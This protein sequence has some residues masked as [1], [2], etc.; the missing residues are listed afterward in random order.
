M[1]KFQEEIIK[2]LKKETKLKEISLEIPSN[3]ELGDYAFPCFVLSKQMKKN[4]VDIAK[5]LVGKISTNDIIKEVKSVGPYLNFFVNRS[6]Q[7]QDL[8]KNILKKGDDFGKQKFTGKKILVEFPGPNTNKPLHLGHVR[9]IVLGTT[10]SKILEMNGHKAVHVNVN[11]DRGIAICKS[12]LAYQKW[13]KNDTP[14]KSKM[15]S[16]FFVGKYY[17]MFAQKVKEHPELDEEAQE[18]VRKWEAGDKEILALWEKMNKWAFDGFKETY[19][20]FEIKP[21]KEYYESETYKNGKDIILQGKKDGLFEEGEEGEIFVD[22]TNRGYDKKVLLRADGTTVYITQDI[23]L[24]KVRYED[25]KFDKSVY[26]VATEQNYH[27]KVLFEVLKLLG[28]P[29]ADKLHHFSYGMVNLTTGKMKSREGTVVDADNLIE[30]MTGLAKKSTKEKHK[31]LSDKEIEKRANEIAMAAIRFYLLKHDP[32]K[33]MLF[34]PEK[35]ISFEG[36]TGPYLQYTY[37]RINS[38]IAKYKG[39]VGDKVDSTLL[40]EKEEL[41]LVKMLANFEEIVKNVGENYKIHSLTRYLLDLA[42]AFNNFY[43]N[44]PVLKAE[45]ELMKSRILLISCVKQVIKNGLS[46]LGIKVL[47]RM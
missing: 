11:N 2:I 30:D 10:L 44:Y 5:E 39:D 42:Q 19:K 18:M 32:V 33:D 31:E 16:D 14:E 4:P 47:E 35:S 27:F 34:D 40:V 17:V 23:Y 13:G 6:G 28:Y 43:H 41:E 7:S 22:L 15:K 46:M 8:L 9:N 25:F 45:E 1:D 3:S 38:I 37:A 24:A 21:E 20:K 29:F 12:M 26:V 36:E